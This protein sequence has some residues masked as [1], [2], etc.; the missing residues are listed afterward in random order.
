VVLPVFKVKLPG[1]VNVDAVISSL[2]VAVIAAFTEMFVA[3]FAGV[4]EET[5]GGVASA[6]APV[7]NDHVLS[8]GIALPAR[9]VTPL[10]TVAVYWVEFA[11]GLASGLDG[12]KVAVKPLSL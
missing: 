3:L 7:V 12:S 11:S 10:V 9:S 8:L 1:T 2:K 5:V 4:V 6:A